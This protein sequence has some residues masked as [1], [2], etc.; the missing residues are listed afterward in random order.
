MK[1][2]F[3]GKLTGGVWGLE[4]EFAPCGLEGSEVAFLALMTSCT[5]LVITIRDRAVLG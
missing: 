5:D 3:N 4:V 1:L 2:V